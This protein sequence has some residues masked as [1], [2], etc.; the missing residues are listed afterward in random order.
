METKKSTNC[1]D[2]KECMKGAPWRF[3]C[4]YECGEHEFCKRCKYR[5]LS[6][7]T[8]KG[9]KNENTIIQKHV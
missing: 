9:E 5:N 3:C 7:L 4:K 6:K 2:C 8:F 1:N